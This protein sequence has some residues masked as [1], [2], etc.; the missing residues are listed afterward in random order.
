MEWV[1][2]IPGG[3][4]SLID[5]VCYWAPQECKQSAE[6]QERKKFQALPLN[7]PKDVKPGSPEEALFKMQE[8]GLSNAQR[9]QLRATKA[10]Y[11]EMAALHPEIKDSAN[12]A[13]IM[14]YLVLKGAPLVAYNGAEVPLA[15]DIEQWEAAYAWKLANGML[16]IDPSLMAAQEVRSAQMKAQEYLDRK[17][18]TEDELDA[19]ATQEISRRATGW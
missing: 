8:E 7:L 2:E 3:W 5:G 19:W 10:A 17:E 15:P 9:M 14:E 12:A 11:N 4:Q 16:R 6:A 13:Q 18:P 1:K